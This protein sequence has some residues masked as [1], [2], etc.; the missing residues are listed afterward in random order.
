MR[1]LFLAFMAAGTM[2]VGLSNPAAAQKYPYCFKSKEAGTECAFKTLKECK[3]TAAGLEGECFKNFR[4]A[5]F[6][7]HR[8][9][10]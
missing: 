3:A 6:A 8:V 7:K 5:A 10:Q 4:S 9:K 1:S 2:V